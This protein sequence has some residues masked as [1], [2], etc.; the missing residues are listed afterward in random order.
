MR[1][2]VFF[3]ARDEHGVVLEAF[4]GVQCHERD[5]AARVVEVVS[6]GDERD[7]G[8]KVDEPPLGIVLLKVARH[9]HKL[10]D[11]LGARLVLRVATRAQ[12]REV[13]GGLDD[14]RE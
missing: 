13:A 2:Q 3:D 12:A 9:R 7:L 1:Q 8:E 10:F 11:V 4:G 5:G 6:R 14:A